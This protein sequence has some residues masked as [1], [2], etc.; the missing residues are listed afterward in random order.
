MDQIEIGGSWEGI[1]CPYTAN[2]REFTY[3]TSNALYSVNKIKFIF[4]S[5][6]STYNNLVIKASKFTTDSLELDLS[7]GLSGSIEQGL[8]I[9]IGDLPIRKLVVRAANSADNF[10]SLCRVLLFEPVTSG[11]SDP[12]CTMTDASGLYTGASSVEYSVD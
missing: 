2:N 6:F 7:S 9:D 8:E 5:D 10:W 3:E 4:G 12:T 1:G 11:G